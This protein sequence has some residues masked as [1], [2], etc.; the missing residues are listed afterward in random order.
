MKR[1]LDG[2][3]RQPRPESRTG[4]RR[5]GSQ[6]VN[7]SNHYTVAA[8]DAPSASPRS[9]APRCW[10]STASG[11]RTPPTSPSS[12]SARSRW[13]RRCRC[14]RGT[15]A[16]LPSTGTRT[17]ARSRT[18]A[19][20]FPPDVERA[21]VEKGREPQQPDG[22]QLLRRSAARAE[23][24]GARHRRHD[25][26]LETALARHPARGARADLHGVGRPVAVVA[27]AR[28]RPHPA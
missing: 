17:R 14:S 27:P 23:R 19:S 22:H 1:Q 16:S 26:V 13:T 11:S 21:R 28:R 4:L 15:S 24:A 5:A 7:T 6:Q 20:R 10:R 18:S 9:T 8:A 12:W 3:R 25:R 2:R